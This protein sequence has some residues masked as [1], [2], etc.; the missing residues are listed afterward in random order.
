MKLAERLIHVEPGIESYLRRPPFMDDLYLIGEDGQVLDFSLT[1]SPQM[2]QFETRLGSFHLAF[3]DANTLVFGLPGHVTAGLRFRVN[4]AHWYKTDSGGEVKHVRNMSYEVLN[5]RVHANR[6]TASFPGVEILVE[7]DQDCSICLHTW[8]GPRRDFEAKPYS[9]ASR[10]A[11]ERW[12]AW[13]DRVPPVNE[14]HQRKYA[15]AWWVMGNNLVNPRGY[16]TRQAMVPSKA[17]YVG[18]WL[19]D[20]ALHAIA[21]RHVDAELARDQVRVMLAQ[22]EPDGMLPDAIFDEGVVNEIDHPI[23]GRVT[24]PPIMAWAVCKLH[25]MHPDRGFLHEVYEAL[26]SE[27]RWWF[28]RNETGL[29]LVHY[30]H[31][32]SSGLDDSPLWDGGMPVASPDINTYLQIQMESLAAIAE[33]IG[34]TEQAGKWREQAAALTTRMITHL[35]EEG[36][37]T[38]QAIHQGKAVPV[39][40]PFNLLPLWTGQLPVRYT[41]RLVSHLNDPDEFMGKFRLP[42]V[43][44]NDPK[45][46]S[47]TMWRGPVWANINYFFIEALERVDKTD[48]AAEL[49]EH[50]LEMISAQPGISEYYDSQTGIAPPTAIPAFGWTAAVYI[51]LA[52]Q[53]SRA[54]VNKG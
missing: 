2:L 32:Y 24:K 44:F 49:R 18:T 51:E 30:A 13:F 45:Y 33:S 15:Y 9:I 1:T 17:S 21:Y 14:R 8:D 23:H 38:F 5:G 11:T 40:T 36:S 29:G 16:L 6:S 39:L 12:T 25:D 50:T 53:A 19:W 3:Q 47:Q 34:K 41:D 22:Q 20:S 35:W 48:L 37:G 4:S 26:V 54:L 31:P 7:A 43:A 46:D 52:I 10:E 27:N 28:E 42:T